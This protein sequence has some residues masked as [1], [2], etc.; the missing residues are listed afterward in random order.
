MIAIIYPDSTYTATHTYF[1]ESTNTFLGVYEIVYSTS[2]H[3]NSVEPTP[4]F[5]HVRRV[6]R[7]EDRYITNKSKLREILQN[8]NRCVNNLHWMKPLGVKMLC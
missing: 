3:E 2:T 6:D 7:S 4:Y 5:S 1:G 8:C